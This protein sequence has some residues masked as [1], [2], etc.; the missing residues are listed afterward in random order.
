MGFLAAADTTQMPTVVQAQCLQTLEDMDAVKTAARA[1]VLAAFTS[2]QGYH[3]DAAYSSR[4]WLIHQ[5]R[6]TK[7]RRPGISSGRSGR[8]GPRW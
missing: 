3:E 2:A 8:C 1:R 5:T 4:T 6:I 7:G